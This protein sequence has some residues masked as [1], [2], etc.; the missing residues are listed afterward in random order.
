MNFSQ[1]RSSME[2]YYC[3]KNNNKSPMNRMD[4]PGPGVFWLILC[5]VVVFVWFDC[6]Y[7]FKNFFH[8]PSFFHLLTVWRWSVTPFIRPVLIWRIISEILCRHFCSHNENIFSVFSY[9]ASL[10]LPVF[11]SLFCSMG[12]GL[13]LSDSDRFYDLIFTF[14]LLY[15]R[16]RFCFE[17]SMHWLQEVEFS[18]VHTFFVRWILDFFY[19]F[20]I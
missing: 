15:L 10:Y 16:C 6:D 2:N 8:L 9:F 19:S 18:H 3:T 4:R 13:D 5:F 17:V 7:R 1:S 20:F 14:G 12:F 11:L